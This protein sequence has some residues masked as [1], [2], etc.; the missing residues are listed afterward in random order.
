[1][2][3]IGKPVFAADNLRLRFGDRVILDDVSFT[4]H[5]GERIALLGRNGAG[6]SCLMKIVS[7]VES[8]DSGEL[9]LQKELKRGYLSQEFILD[10]SKTVF[11]NILLLR[12][13]ILSL[14][15]FLRRSTPR[16]LHACCFLCVNRFLGE[17]GVL[18]FIPP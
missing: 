2:A 15:L 14:P 11:E 4:I 10:D 7:G 9:T 5:D 13:I 1:M 18:Q 17:P 16:T 12:V 3:S 6:K 8:A